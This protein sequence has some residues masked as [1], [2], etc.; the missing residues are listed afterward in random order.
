MA[1]V[2]NQCTGLMYTN[3]EKNNENCLSIWATHLYLYRAVKS[4]KHTVVYVKKIVTRFLMHCTSTFSYLSSNSNG[5]V[6]SLALAA[7]PW[8]SAPN[9][10]LK[11]IVLEFRVQI[12]SC[13]PGCASG[14][15][16]A[17]LCSIA[18]TRQDISAASFCS[19]RL[20]WRVLLP[21]FNAQPDIFAV[22][23]CCVVELS[24]FSSDILTWSADSL[25]S[26]QGHIN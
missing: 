25:Y 24:V 14:S 9:S 17:H 23:N 13:K 12:Q 22:M 6:F 20:L 15:P 16:A 19:C 11:K 21:C 3:K 2:Q 26:F 4:S 1:V 8:L 5:R 18:R 7:N 10:S